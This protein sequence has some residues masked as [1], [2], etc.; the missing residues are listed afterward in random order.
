MDY[1]RFVSEGVVGMSMCKRV[2]L[3]FEWTFVQRVVQLCGDLFEPVEMIC[4][5]FLPQL[6]DS[7]FTPEER[8]VFALPVKFAGLGIPA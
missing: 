7:E 5:N 6:L 4:D 2:I 8:A 1:I 3:S